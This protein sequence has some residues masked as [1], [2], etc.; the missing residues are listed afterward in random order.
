MTAVPATI[1]G[2]RVLEGTYEEESGSKYIAVEILAHNGS[3]QV[4]G[5]TD[6]LDVDVATAVGNALRTGATYALR[7]WSISRCARSNGTA[8][9][10]TGTVSGS[11]ISL[12]P[13]TEAS[14]SN[15]ATIA[16]SALQG[17]GR[18]APYKIFV[19]VEVT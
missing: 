3:T 18:Y 15:N 6:T 10:A 7:D 13:K 8:Y 16:A 19:L 11:T 2:V 12:T 17:I 9:A 1:A 5:G 14:W 4:A